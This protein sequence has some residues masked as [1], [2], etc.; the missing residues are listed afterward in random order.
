MKSL[1][2][3]L[4]ITA[5]L[6][7]PESR[8][9]RGQE[10]AAAPPAVPVPAA[11]WEELVNAPVDQIL[12]KYSEL[13]GRHI[14]RPASLAGSITFTNYTP[15]TRAEAIQA[16]DGALALNGITMLPQGEKFVKAVPA[17]QAAAPPA[18]PRP[19]ALPSSPATLQ[20]PPIPA[21]PPPAA[22]RPGALPSSPAL[23]Q[24]PA[25]LAIPRRLH[26]FGIRAHV[27]QGKSLVIRTSEADAKTQ[28]KLEED[29]AVM[30]RI[31]E[32]AL[33][34]KMVEVEDRQNPY[35][36]INVLFGPGSTPIRSL[37]LEGYG[38]L[39]LLNVNFPLL[40][41][42]EKPEAAKEQSETDSAWEE[43]KRELYGQP[44]PWSQV[45]G[46]LRFNMSGA[47][48]K[49]YDEK[50]VDA[51]KDALLAAL[52][53]ATNIRNLKSEETITVC[54]FGG[55]AVL[56]AA[57]GRAEFSPDGRRVVT[58]SADNTV[59]LWE[60]TTGRELLEHND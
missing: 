20:N 16:L 9:L 50:K 55:A 7:L 1:L 37:Y 5:V 33:A 28:A 15:L 58:A 10:P 32:K 25:V 44:D 53:N 6:S 59:R 4:V 2:T 60:T 24:N 3:N 12:E 23:L 31:F 35:M 56:Q 46:A 48:R 17:T 51:R 8:S 22:P 11:E 34:Q 49:E 42:P 45:G 40:P 41:P 29:L 47:P 36:G 43:A 27:G 54:V 19:G 57:V 39:F 30:S 13:T 26:N 14:L 52:N 18:A 21:I 38:A